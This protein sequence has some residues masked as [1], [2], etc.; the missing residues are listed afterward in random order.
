LRVLQFG[1]DLPHLVEQLQ[2]LLL[3]R[4]R[5]HNGDTEPVVETTLRGRSDAWVGARVRSGWVGRR[6]PIGFGEGVT[7]KCARVSTIMMRKQARE[8]E[9]ERAQACNAENS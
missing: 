3:R 9:R 1:D 8:R 7:M 6:V 4:R 5:V 2:P